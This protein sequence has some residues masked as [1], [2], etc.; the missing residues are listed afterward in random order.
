M[1]LVQDRS[2]D[3]LTGSPARYH[4]IMDAPCI[5]ILKID[6]KQ[7]SFMIQFINGKRNIVEWNDYYRTSG[8]ELLLNI[9][10]VVTEMIGV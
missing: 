2:L 7:C 9:H 10:F 8:L 5:T 3:L 1:P 6:P 4:C